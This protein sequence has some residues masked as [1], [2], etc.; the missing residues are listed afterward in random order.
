[1]RPGGWSLTAQETWWS[2]RAEHL[3]AEAGTA[4]SD[5]WVW[6]ASSGY[7]ALANPLLKLSR[8]AGPNPSLPACFADPDAPLPCQDLGRRPRAPRL[9]PMFWYTRGSFV[10]CVSPQSCNFRNSQSS[11]FRLRPRLSRCKVLSFHKYTLAT[12]WVAAPESPSMG[13]QPRFLLG[14]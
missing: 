12:V 2:L 1:M 11:G 6:K 7:T 5:P 13:Q 9:L 10:I 14:Q 8:K 4:P 3:W